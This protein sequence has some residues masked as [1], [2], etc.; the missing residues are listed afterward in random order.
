MF[1]ARVSILALYCFLFIRTIRAIES[2][3]YGRQTVLGRVSTSTTTSS[4]SV[5]NDDN[6]PSSSTIYVDAIVLTNALSE[7]YENIVDQVMASLT[8]DIVSSAPRTFTALHHTR[9]TTT[10]H[11]GIHI[12]IFA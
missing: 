4:A 1:A 9:S 3:R 5:N 12:S 6:Q 7:Y 10:D 2:T 11:H 8:Q